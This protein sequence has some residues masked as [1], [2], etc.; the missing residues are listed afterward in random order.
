MGTINKRTY[1]ETIYT[2]HQGN[3][4][5]KNSDYTQLNSN[6]DSPREDESLPTKIQNNR[7]F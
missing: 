6:S 3:T 7:F 1:N 5:E 4:K 2:K